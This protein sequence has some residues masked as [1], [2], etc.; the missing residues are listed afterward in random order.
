MTKF[1]YRI[2]NIISD[3]DKMNAG[4]PKS[5][6]AKTWLDCLNALALEGWQLTPNQMTKGSYILK[7]EI[8]DK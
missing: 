2:F 4:K 8:T 3:T 7:R 5:L 1:E 6:K